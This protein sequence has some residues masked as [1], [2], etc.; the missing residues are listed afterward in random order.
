MAFT[1]SQARELSPEQANPMNALISRALDTFSK[2]TQ[3]AYLPSQL[4]T[5]IQQKQAASQKNMM[6]AQ[7]LQSLMGGNGMASEQGITSDGESSGNLGGFNKNLNPAILKGILGIDPYLMSPQDTQKLKIAGELKTAANK[8]ALTTGASDISRE[9]LQDKVSMPQEYMGA[10]G[11]ASMSKDMIAAKLGDNDAKERLIKAAVAE[12]LVPEYSGFQLSSQGIKPTVSA[13][14]HQKE[15]IRQGWPLASHQI[16][17]NLPP[18]LQKEAERRHNEIVKGVNKSREAFYNSGGKERPNFSN[19]SKPK[20][21]SWS[22]IK[23]TAQKRGLS[24]N[25][26][27][28]RLAKKSGMSLDQFMQNVEMENE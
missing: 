9:F 8:N 26:V 19:Q 14:Q 6:M 27:I 25:E 11:S 24:E 7:L 13:L 3:A 15:A 28:D 21:I 18:E 10:F 2:G 5:D 4:Q 22:D 16:T 1:F 12:R 23:H 20:S 17:N